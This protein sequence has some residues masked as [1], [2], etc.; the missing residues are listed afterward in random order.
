MKFLDPPRSFLLGEDA[1]ATSLPLPPPVSCRDLA[2]TLPRC[3]PRSPEACDSLPS[4]VFAPQCTLVVAEVRLTCICVPRVRRLFRAS[5]IFRS[6]EMQRRRARDFFVR[7]IWSGRRRDVSR[8]FLITFLFYS[9]AFLRRDIRWRSR[10]LAGWQPAAV[11][12]PSRC[13]KKMAGR[14]S[15]AVVTLARFP[16]FPRCGV[17]SFAAFGLPLRM[18]SSSKNVAG[19]RAIL[20]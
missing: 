8:C 6:G 7:G 11:L 1:A 4:Y 19:R 17:A 15:D 9:V 10:N 3:Y 18:L 13:P 2:A 20:R 14:D 5:A 16:F 12:I